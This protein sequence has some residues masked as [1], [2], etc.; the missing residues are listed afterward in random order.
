[1]KEIILFLKFIFKSIDEKSKLNIVKYNSK[2]QNKIDINLNNYKFFSRR[3]IVYEKNGIAKEYNILT[4]R[5]IFVG[6]YSNGKRNGKGK[7]YYNGKLLFE[8]EYSNG[9]RNGKGKEYI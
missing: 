5:L 2:L 6:E 4:N 7:E 9:K 1:M 3:Y 8:G